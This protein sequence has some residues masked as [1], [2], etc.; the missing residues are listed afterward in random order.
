MVQI[1]RSGFR[2]VVDLEIDERI[3]H[4]KTRREPKQQMSFVNGVLPEDSSGVRPTALLPQSQRAYSNSTW[5][6]KSMVA[7]EIAIR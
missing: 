4:Y 3:F 6:G 1:K 5:K 7:G 2:D